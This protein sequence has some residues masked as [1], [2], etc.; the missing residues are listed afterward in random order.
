MYMYELII[1]HLIPEFKAKRVRVWR[2]AYQ[3]YIADEK[4]LNIILG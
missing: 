2:R 3:K 1:R 4:E